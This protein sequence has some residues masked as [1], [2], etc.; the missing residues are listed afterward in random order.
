MNEIWKPVKNYEG[1]YEISSLGNI[2]SIDRLISRKMNDGSIRKIMLKG[3]QLK[4]CFMGT[5]YAVTLCKNGKSK[6]C[7]IH[8]LVGMA[9]IENP[10]GLECIN[11]KDENKLNNSVENLEWCDR[12]YNC[13]Y[14][15]RNSTISKKNR[16]PRV[17][18]KKVAQYSKSGEF[19]K[20]YDNPITAY[21]ETN[22]NGTQIK[23]CCEGKR[24]QAGNYKWKYV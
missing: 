6:Q 5:Y 21:R 15:I 22:I 8:R 4:K 9:F 13:N 18:F 14:G 24:K 19:I 1:L 12:M 17:N 3:K 7:L 10:N 16:R 2:R 23:Y 20:E 11:H